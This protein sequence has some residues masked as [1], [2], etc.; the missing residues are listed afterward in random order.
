MKVSKEC[1]KELI[2][3]GIICLIIVV[4]LI[5]GLSTATPW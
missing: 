1:E 4:S 3:L 5:I 2:I